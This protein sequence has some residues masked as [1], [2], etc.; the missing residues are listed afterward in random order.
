MQLLRLFEIQ[1][2][3]RE[4]SDDARSE[5]TDFFPW[6]VIL[7]LEISTLNFSKIRFEL[8]LTPSCCLISCFSV[9]ELFGALLEF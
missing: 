4:D 3:I 1:F 7:G 9:N 5:D 6:C 2:V 8:L